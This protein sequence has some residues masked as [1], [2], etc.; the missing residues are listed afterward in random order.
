MIT[1]K[2]LFTLALGLCVSTEVFAMQPMESTDAKSVKKAIETNEAP[3][4]I[5][6]YSQAIFVPKGKNMLFISGQL[7]LDPKTGTLVTDI[8]PAT[9]LIMSNL[10]AILKAA[11]MNFSNVVQTTI[12]LANINDFPTVNKLYG[13]FFKDM[14]PPARATFQAGAL[15][16]GAIVEIAMVAAAD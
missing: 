5:G 1:N 4:A 14:V 3:A 2:V 12:L 9:M 13:S 7:P 8:E 16:R 15:P 10:L 11:G 6:P